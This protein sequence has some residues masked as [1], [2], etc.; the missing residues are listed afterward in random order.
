M[1]DI[2][3][4]GFMATC[5]GGPGCGS[6]R[7]PDLHAEL[8]A[9]VNELVTTVEELAIERRFKEAIIESWRTNGRART[10]TQGAEWAWQATRHLFTDEDTAT[11]TDAADNLN[12][13]LG[14]RQ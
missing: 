2:E 6:G 8:E 10:V 9:A 1:C 14:E 7:A 5:C 11:I 4:T 12:H 3:D 13:K